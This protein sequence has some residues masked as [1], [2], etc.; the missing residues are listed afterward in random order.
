MTSQQQFFGPVHQVAGGDIINTANEMLWHR[1]SEE[2]VDEKVRC[3]RKLLEAR[4]KI[5]FNIPVAWLV[6]GVIGLIW[7][8]NTGPLFSV[9]HAKLL[10]WFIVS[11]VAAP[12]FFVSR[13]LR[14]EGVVVHY[15]RTRLQLIKLILRDR[16]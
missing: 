11:G 1:D 10:F 9:D 7:I 4:T 14:S 2:L 16:A 3:Q 5:F 12:G 8:V 6:L 13:M 15:Y